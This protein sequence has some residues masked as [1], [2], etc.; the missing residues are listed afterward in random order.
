MWRKEWLR[1]RRELGSH[2]TILREFQDGREHD[3]IQYMRMDVNSFYTLLAKV[4][5]YIRKQD[6]HFRQS[7]SAEARLEAT[8]RFLASGWS[9]TSL[10]YTTRISKQSLSLIIPETCE[11][12]Y[13]VLTDDYLQV[14][15]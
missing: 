12:I 2:L 8:L 10:Q 7:I 6:T 9:Y 5:P 13:A 3:F 11:A 14:S 1:R 15:F 4:E